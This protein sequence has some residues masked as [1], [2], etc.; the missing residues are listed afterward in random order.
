[1][2]N[3]II[4]DNPFVNRSGKWEILSPTGKDFAPSIV[5]EAALCIIYGGI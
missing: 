2:Q 4:F 5:T 1:M 3:I